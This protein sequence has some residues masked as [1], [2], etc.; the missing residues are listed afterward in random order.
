MAERDTVTYDI[1]GYSTFGGV[2][3]GQP[4]ANAHEEG[5]SK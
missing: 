4:A 1:K 3:A 2:A 5:T